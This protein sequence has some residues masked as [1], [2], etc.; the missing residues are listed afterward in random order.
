MNPA[1]PVTTHFMELA[2]LQVA[3]KD[4]G[5]PIVSTR[6]TALQPRPPSA[7][8]VFCLGSHARC[9]MFRWLCAVIMLAALPPL[10]A[11]E[12]TPAERGY[13]ALTETAFIPAFWKS[14]SVANAWKA[15]GGRRRSPRTT[16]RPSATATACT[17]LLIPTTA[18]RWGCGRPTSCSGQALGRIACSATA[19]RFS[20]RATS[21]WA[22]AR[23]TSRPSSRTWQRPVGNRAS[24]PSRSRTSAAPTR[25]MASASICSAF[26][27]PT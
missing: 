1:A 27:N 21:A 16:T 5:R 15:M 6:N 25:R 17:P 20:A 10:R 23:S 18:C 22:T 19:A 26:A 7:I 9:I 14:N 4:C 13:K 12:P 8:L 11:A 3:A 24:C 2:S